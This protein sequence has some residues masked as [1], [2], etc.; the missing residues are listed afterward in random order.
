MMEKINI[1][2]NDYCVQEF[3]VILNINGEEQSKNIGMNTITTFELD[4]ISTITDMSCNNGTVPT[5]ENNT[6]TVTNIFGNTTCKM[7][8]S[9]EVT[10]T[11]LNDTETNV[12]MLSD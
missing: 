8:D 2:S 3:T 1:T 12:V 9:L 6:L 5:I 4:D 7:N 11:S 10:M